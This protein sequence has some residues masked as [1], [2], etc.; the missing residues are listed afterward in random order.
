[1][2]RDLVSVKA[3]NG[4][5]YCV[6]QHADPDEFGIHPVINGQI[7]KSKSFAFMSKHSN[8]FL[9]QTRNAEAATIRQNVGI[10]EVAPKI[11]TC[12]QS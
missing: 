4:Q 7:D 1:M 9:S 6:I 12:I 3:L 10:Q 11:E 5:R 8:L 2:R